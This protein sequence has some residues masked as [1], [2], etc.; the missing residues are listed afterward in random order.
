MP[1]VE[2]AGHFARVKVVR[3][4]DG[5][6]R[7]RARRGQVDVR[8]PRDEAAAMARGIVDAVE[9]RFEGAN[10][11][12]G[13]SHGDLRVR[14]VREFV[15]RVERLVDA[16]SP[17]AR[18]G[19]ADMAVSFDRLVEDGG[20]PLFEYGVVGPEAR[21]GEI[22]ATH[23]RLV[24]LRRFEDDRDER[25]DA[26]RLQMGANALARIFVARGVRAAVVRGECGRDH[27]FAE[28]ETFCGG[29]LAVAADH[30]VGAGERHPIRL[31]AVDDRRDL[32]S[33]Q[34]SR[35]TRPSRQ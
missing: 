33:A 1:D 34:T 2:I 28:T 24:A 35:R 13:K 19:I 18:F 30:L 21:R 20:E 11:I 8:R 23:Q 4:S 22:E 16:R 17:I 25:I 26:H 7:G 3:E 32:V 10:R 27:V 6:R 5:F 29:A 31:A 14:A 15:D 12:F 9:R